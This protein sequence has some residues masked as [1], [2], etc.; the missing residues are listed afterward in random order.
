V[1]IARAG[2][3]RLR[4]LGRKRCTAQVDHCRGHA[5]C[6]QSGGGH[7]LPAPRGGPWPSTIGPRGICPARG[8][9]Q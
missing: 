1:G 8:R 7:P 6:G 9:I 3:A 5:G 2:M 4:R